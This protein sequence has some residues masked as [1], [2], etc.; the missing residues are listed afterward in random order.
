MNV[1]LAKILTLTLTAAILLSFAAVLPAFS[2]GADGQV[3]MINPLSG[4]ENFIFDT[5][6]MSYGSTFVVRIMLEPNGTL[7]LY[8]WQVKVSYPTDLLDCM[9]DAL[10]AGH[11]FEGLSYNHPDPDI[12]ESAGTC[13]S[14]VNLLSGYKNVSAPAPLVEITFKITAAPT[15][16]DPVV[17][18]NFTFLKINESGGTYLLDSVG[19]K[20]DIEYIG[21]YYEFSWVVPPERP[22]LEVVDPVDSNHEI[23]ADSI[24]QV[25]DID[26]Y[27]G[28]CSAGWEMI[29]V[30]FELWYNTTLLS[31]V[32]TAVSPEFVNGTFMENF[33]GV[34]EYGIVYMVKADFEGTSGPHGAPL[35]QNYFLV[36]VMKMPA[37]SGDWIPPF[38]NG[39]GKLITLKVQTLLQGLFPETLTC[40][41]ELKNVVFYNRYGDT[42][43][44]GVHT[45]GTYKMLPKVL[46]R[47]VDVFTQ[48]PKPYGGQGLFQ[49]SDMF[50]PQKEVILY[51]SVTYNEWPEQNKDVVFQIIDP[52]G[53]TWA[54]LYARTNEMGVATTSFRLP[55][56]C[57]TPEDWFGEWTVIATVDVAGEIKND[58]LHF[59]YDFLV[60][61][62]KVTTDKASY[63]HDE[64]I[65]I[66][67]DF[68]SK[69]MQKYDV[70]ITITALDETG[71][72]F[73]YI[74]VK[75]QIGGA[76][77]CHYKD[78]T[79][80]GSIHVVKWARA[81]VA[82][83]VVG[84]LND[85]PFE[86][87][88]VISGPFTPITVQILAEWA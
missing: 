77:Y 56:P 17:S 35:G 32:G 12:D 58:T 30:Q 88:T 54:I 70:T 60:H 36:G 9:G 82:Q 76:V 24:G 18:G 87:G 6:T 16:L 4:D 65:G 26:I 10:P 81:G 38:P 47:M 66:T 48:Y 33:V 51:A 15:I 86:G 71:V 21:G 64:A 41:L 39:E 31:Y 20:F 75:T 59:H 52:D 61:I 44:P 46:G 1:K 63:K 23:V 2:A 69:A 67:V 7:D 8:G 29:S 73:G 62:V 37:M 3:K 72:P 57:D 83:I 80:S 28:N 19:E 84:A 25:K 78:Y 5:S 74:Y 34:G 79:Q 11:V 49:D 22:Y 43:V 42:L 14:M 13:F 40:D 50:W 27:I 45:S 55:W 68:K 85:F 53:V